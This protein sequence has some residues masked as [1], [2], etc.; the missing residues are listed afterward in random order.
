MDV[1]GDVAAEELAGRFTSDELGVTWDIELTE[2]QLHLGRRKHNASP[3]FPVGP[4]IFA[5][6]DADFPMEFA[7]TRDK[8]GHVDGFRLNQGRIRNIA[9][10]SD[11]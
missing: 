7:F 9:F 8:T 2:G 11:A 6:S 10:T 1:P 3:L 4:D 5:G